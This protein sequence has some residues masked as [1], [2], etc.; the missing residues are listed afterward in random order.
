[1]DYPADSSEDG[2]DEL[3]TADSPSAKRVY[4]DCSEDEK[5]SDENNYEEGVTWKNYWS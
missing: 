1:M 3:R 2:S 4:Y 5:S